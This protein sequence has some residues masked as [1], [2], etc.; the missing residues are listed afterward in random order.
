M[1]FGFVCWFEL[2]VGY[3][4]LITGCELLFLRVVVCVVCDV[5]SV[6]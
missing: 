1:L 2:F 3:D 5:F 4:L 6:L